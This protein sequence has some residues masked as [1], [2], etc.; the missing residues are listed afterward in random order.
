MSTP[1]SSLV[2]GEKAA[3]A[4]VPLLE[5]AGDPMPAVET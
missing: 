1:G 3:V 4:Y 2:R 5:P